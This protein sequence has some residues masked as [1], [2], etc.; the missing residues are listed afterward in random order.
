MDD[1]SSIFVYLDELWPLHNN[2]TSDCGDTQRDR[3]TLPV[4]KETSLMESDRGTL[5]VTKETS[6]MESEQGNFSCR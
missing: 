1:E 4:T 6:L 3:G 5:P 2:Y